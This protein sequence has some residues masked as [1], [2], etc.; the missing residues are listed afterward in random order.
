LGNASHVR[1]GALVEFANHV[2]LEGVAALDLAPNLVGFAIAGVDA[3]HV[4][5][6]LG[7]CDALSQVARALLEEARGDGSTISSLCGGGE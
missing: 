4:A 5:K 2:V 6:A 3:E 1:H 7:V